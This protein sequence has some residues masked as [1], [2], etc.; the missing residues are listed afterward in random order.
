MWLIGVGWAVARTWTSQS[1]AQVEA[2]FE[3]LEG[4]FVILRASDGRTFKILKTQLSAEDQS[5]VDQAVA[6]APAAPPETPAR[7]PPRAPIQNPAVEWIRYDPAP[8]LAL[9]QFPAL[10]RSKAANMMFVGIQYGPAPRETLYCAFEME[11]PQDPPTLLHIYDPAQGQ[12]VTLRA[13]R[14]KAGEHRVTSF[15]D[16]RRTATY[17][18]VRM[19][20]NIEFLCGFA[21]NDTV[22]LTAQVDLARSDATA[23]FLI[24]G[25]LNN[26]F[27]YGP[28]QIN[29][30]PFLEPPELNV[31][32]WMMRGPVLTGYC[33]IG[34]WSLIPK[35]GMD[36][37][38]A[39]EIVD[40]ESGKSL[41][42]TNGQFNEEKLLT[43]A[44]DKTLLV[45]L[46]LEPER[47]V[48]INA[49]MNLGPL[50]G[51]VS[52]TVNFY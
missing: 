33:K 43:G 30:I 42:Q 6:P 44:P 5:Y 37:V 51:P 28:G 31:R 14:R 38:L 49:S 47:K 12:P 41:G 50:L 29:V 3:K 36:R 13:V 26:D 17:G 18:S 15:R 27:T 25:Y 24:G 21:R 32:A 20:A 46:R 11:N 34:R 1:G 22:L 19:T 16:I 10:D 2:E 48:S 52:R 8:S 40:R 45:F 9:E 35:A 39:V 4:D 7:P 23:Q